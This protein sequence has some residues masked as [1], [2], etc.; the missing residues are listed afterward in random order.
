MPRNGH[1]RG[2]PSIGESGRER[3]HPNT[4]IEGPKWDFGPTSVILC[5][6][7]VGAVAYVETKCVLKVK[8][9]SVP[10]KDPY[11]I[12]AMGAKFLSSRIIYSRVF[13]HRNNPPLKLWRPL[14][15]LSDRAPSDRYLT[16]LNPQYRVSY[17]F[18]VI[19]ADI[20]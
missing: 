6:N 5:H 7:S 17:P 15:S 13:R 2:V 8:L 19:F 18:S 10:K 16:D 20:R 9:L 14:C 1:W 4:N 3:P 11:K 12:L